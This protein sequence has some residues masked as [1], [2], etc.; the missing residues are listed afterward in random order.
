MTQYVKKVKMID[1][2]RWGWITL[3]TIDRTKQRFQFPFNVDARADGSSPASW[4]LWGS[5]WSIEEC[6][7]HIQKDAKLTGFQFRI[8]EAKTGRVLEVFK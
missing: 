7:K 3:V 4:M 6:K 1:C 5:G 8:V 2:D